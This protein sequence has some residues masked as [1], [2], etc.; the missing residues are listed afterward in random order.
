MDMG[1]GVLQ[2]DS[3]LATYHCPRNITNRSAS[4]LSV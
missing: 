4:E 1:M 3:L 2:V